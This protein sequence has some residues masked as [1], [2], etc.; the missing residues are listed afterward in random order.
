MLLDHLGTP[1]PTRPRR[2]RR[3]KNIQPKRRVPSAATE[4]A[5]RNLAPATHVRLMLAAKHNINDTQYGPGEV[6]V[7]TDVAKVLQEQERRAAWTDHNF[8]STRACV[9]GPG[10]VKGGV[11]VTEVAPEYFDTQALDA[12]PLGVVNRTTLQYTAY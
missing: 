5:R 2:Q 12:V 4:T 8:A 7:T 9:I 3:P 1:I 11:S 6:T 10:R